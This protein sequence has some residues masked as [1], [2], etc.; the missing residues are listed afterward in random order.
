MNKTKKTVILVVVIISVLIVV[1]IF[2]IIISKILETNAK[3]KLLKAFPRP[4]ITGTVCEPSSFDLSGGNI[5]LRN[6]CFQGLFVFVNRFDNNT[7]I[8][9]KTYTV[10]QYTE[11]KSIYRYN[12]L[13]NQ[14]EYINSDTNNLLYMN[15]NYNSWFI[16]PTYGTIVGITK[17]WT[18]IE[19]K[20]KKNGFLVWT[21]TLIDR[22]IQD[23]VSSAWIV[24]KI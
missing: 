5:R 22:S 8:L 10:F 13:T 1:S 15:T 11:E 16:L 24:E 7:L 17:K 2:I 21:L 4:R 3:K 14:E 18:I 6:G 12:S 20:D 9:S 23:P 19:R